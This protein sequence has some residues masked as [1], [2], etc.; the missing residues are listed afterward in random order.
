MGK[1]PSIPDT[2]NDVCMD[3][4]CTQ[5]Y[6]H[7]YALAHRGRE[8]NRTCMQRKTYTVIPYRQIHTGNIPKQSLPTRPS[9]HSVT[10]HEVTLA[11]VE[12]TPH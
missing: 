11:A 5:T 10:L 7:V 1:D 2:V 9:F 6:G 12:G 3:N 8:T 4:A